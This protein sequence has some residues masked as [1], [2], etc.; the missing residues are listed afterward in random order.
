MSQVWI[1]KIKINQ[2]NKI[3]CNTNLDIIDTQKYKNE[4]KNNNFVGEINYFSM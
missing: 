2:E 3:I 1:L 4:R